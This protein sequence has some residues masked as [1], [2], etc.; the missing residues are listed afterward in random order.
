MIAEDNPSN[1][2]PDEEVSSDDEYGYN[3]YKYRHT[4]S[5]DEAFD[6]DDDNL[7]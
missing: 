1:D 2:Y 6:E 7:G 5:D 4:R 3:P